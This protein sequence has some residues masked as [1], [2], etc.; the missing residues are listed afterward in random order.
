MTNRFILTAPPP[1]VQIFAVER[2]GQFYIEVIELC[3]NGVEISKLIL[4]K[5]VNAYFT[6][7]E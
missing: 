6:I 4:M 7:F 1:A 2:C 5:F 3:I